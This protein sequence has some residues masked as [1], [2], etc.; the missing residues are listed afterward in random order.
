MFDNLLWYFYLLISPIITNIWFISVHTVFFKKSVVLVILW[1][2]CV[3]VCVCVCLCVCRVSIALCGMWCQEFIL[4]SPPRFL[5]AVQCMMLPLRN[6]KKQ[7]CTVPEK[8]VNIWT[9]YLYSTV[10][11]VTWP[12]S[13]AW[14][15]GKLVYPKV[16][17]FLVSTSVHVVQYITRVQLR[18]LRDDVHN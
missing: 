14:P 12:R 1:A 2:V 10:V 13:L 9:L 11:Y 18:K 15:C 4:E 3:C 17:P 7:L 16:T 8:R 6:W 5:S